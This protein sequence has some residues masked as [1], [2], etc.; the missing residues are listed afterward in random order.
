[1]N[2]RKS[3]KRQVGAEHCFPTSSSWVSRLGV[4]VEV[5]DMVIVAGEC[6]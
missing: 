6:W 3:T 1:M 2:G 4:G 5:L